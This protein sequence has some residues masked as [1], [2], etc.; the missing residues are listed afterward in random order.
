MAGSGWFGR[1]RRNRTMESVPEGIATKCVKCHQII[2]ARDFETRLVAR[3]PP[4]VH[5]SPLRLRDL[6]REQPDRTGA[7]DE[8]TVALV[9][10]PHRQRLA[11]AR[12]RLGQRSDATVEPVGDAVE[13]PRRNLQARREA[14]VDERPDRSPLRADRL[15]GGQWSDLPVGRDSHP[16][17]L[18][19]CNHGLAPSDQ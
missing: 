7:D 8:H 13:V 16:P 6:R 3:R 4:H 9:H 1:N 17:D 15:A 14:T 12:E 19:Q 2:F 18:A 5:R 10:R 11:A